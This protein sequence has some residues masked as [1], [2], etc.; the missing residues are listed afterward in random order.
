MNKY[1]IYLIF[2]LVLTSCV[3]SKK[4]NEATRKLSESEEENR[5]LKSNNQEYQVKTTELQAILK[6]LQAEYKIL[7]DTWKVAKADLE[8]LHDTKQHL[9][10]SLNDLENQLTTV[11]KG[12]SEE[13][14]LLLEKLQT[15]QADI[16]AREDKLR[17]TQSELDVKNARLTELQEAL[18][19]KDE[20]VKQLK[21]K[22][23]GALTGFNNN[24]LSINE[25]NGKVYVSMDERLLFKT[26]EWKVDEKGKQ[27]LK[28]LG[29]VLAQNPDINI[30]VEGH[31]DDV[32]MRG[33]GEVVDNW[34]LSVVR[35][36]AVTRIL[37]LNKSIDPQRITSAGRSEF[38]P[39]ATG[40]T[41]EDRQKNRRT[42]IIL[43]P[44]LDEIFKILESN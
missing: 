28:S 17:Q 18:A 7:Q 4:F 26:G 30:M 42:E 40:K 36:T 5:T 31:T 8:T 38:V 12:S 23:M 37:L 27:A 2:A 3:S 1:T 24:G 22:V 14:G 29:E 16:Q 9:Q 32:P 35:A 13:I 21:Q 6:N 25:R 20:A 44:R 34:D 10:E 39:I 15:V 11:K 33:T 43:T 41:T 19:Q